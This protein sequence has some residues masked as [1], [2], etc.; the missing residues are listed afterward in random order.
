MANAIKCP[1]CEHDVSSNLVDCPHCK[2][3]IPKQVVCYFCNEEVNTLDG[4]RGGVYN[5]FYHRGCLEKISKERSCPE[6]EK[7]L[8]KYD[9]GYWNSPDTCPN[10]GHRLWGGNCS[11]CSLGLVGNNCVVETASDGYSSYYH[12]ACQELNLKRH[13]LKGGNLSSAAEAYN[14]TGDRS[15]ASQ[16][17]HALSRAQCME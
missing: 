5:Y 3:T 11:R 8:P 10:C 16:Q 4:V 17:V 9:E 6:C 2:R 15:N 13:S 7:M 14:I 12:K 1:Y